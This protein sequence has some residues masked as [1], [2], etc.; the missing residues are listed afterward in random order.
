MEP[1]PELA[2]NEIFQTD[3]QFDIRKYQQ[4]LTGPTANEELLLQLEQ[5]Y[6]DVVPRAKLM[7]QITAGT[8]V[9]DV[10]LWQAYRDRTE[11]AT[12]DYLALDLAQLVPGDVEVSDAEI[13]E[14]YEAHAEEFEREP[15]A[16]LSLAYISKT[17]TAADTAAALERAREL[18]AE[19][20]GGVDFAEVAR[21]ESGD[22]GSREAGGALGRFGRGQMVPAFEEAAWELPIGEVSEPVL[23]PF[24]YHLIEVE[25]RE[26][27]EVEARHILVSLERSEESLDRLYTRADSLEDLAERAGLR[28]AARATEATIQSD[29]QVSEGNAL[30]ADVGSVTEALEW[31]LDEMEAGAIN[32]TAA[33]PLF[34]T[35]QAFYVAEAEAVSPAGRIPLPEAA[36]RIRRELILEKKRGRAR[37]IGGQMVEEIRGGKT[38]EQ[39]AR[40]RGIEVQTAGPFARLGFNPA[41]GQANAATGAAFGTP[42]GQVSDVVGTPLGLYLIRPTS[43]TEADRAGWEAQKEQQRQGEVMRVQQEVVTRWLE[44]LRERAEI[45]DNRAEVL[46]R[47]T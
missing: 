32:S 26:G 23:T 12:V 4:F 37:E 20:L 6:R 25:E 40:E 9:S 33:S 15:S 43:R 22:P 27:D 36:P 19:I 11:Q 10:E 1:H 8:Y 44:G 38:L 29:V 46:Q 21:R 39:V 31:A 45:V 14:Y 13:R 3:G 28:R 7:R 47:S 34:E 16:R 5:Y 17:P 18:R 41:F 42:I 30:V 24:G 35:E 2:Q